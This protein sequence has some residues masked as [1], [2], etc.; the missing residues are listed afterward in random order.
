MPTGMGFDPASLITQGAGTIFG[1][2]LQDYNDQRQLSQQQKLQQLQIRGQKEMTDYNMSKQ[3]QMWKDTNYPAQIEQLKEAGLNPALI[4]GTSGGGATTTGNANG[5]VSGAEAPRG[6]QEIIAE[7]GMAMQL[8]LQKAQIANINAD[9]ENKKAENPNIPKAGEKMTAETQSILQG[10]SNQKAQQILTEAETKLKN[11]EITFTGD[12]LNNRESIINM[13]LSGMI[14]SVQSLADQRLVDDATV[15]TKISLLRQELANKILDSYLIKA[16]TTATDQSVQESM[17][18][19]KS[20]V[21]KTM[22]DW[23]S[24]SNDN[25][26]VQLQDMEQDW[27]QSGLPK[28]LQDILRSIFILPIGGKGITPIRGFHDR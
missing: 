23:D 14:E 7:Q 10:I 22:Q 15:K 26:R 1:L 25:K 2:A 27:E 19:V 24:L 20:M 3:L 17:Q 21:A 12:T 13:T 5:N 4:Y 18:R 11:I 28:G 16:Q 6:G 8:A 9:T